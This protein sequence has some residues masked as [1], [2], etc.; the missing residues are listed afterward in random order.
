MGIGANPLEDGSAVAGNKVKNEAG[1]IDSQ[2]LP[3]FTPPTPVALG[4]GSS[5]LQLVSW[6]SPAL[7]AAFF[8]PHFQEAVGFLRL[9]SEEG[10]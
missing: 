1:E 2:G 8:P 5:H 9:R 6:A 7:S 4:I 3:S 10:Q